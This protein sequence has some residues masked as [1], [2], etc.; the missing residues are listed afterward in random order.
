MM[1]N[2]ITYSNRLKST[3]NKK[4]YEEQEQISKK[5][6]FLQYIFELIE[7]VDVEYLDLCTSNP[8][9]NLA[10][11]DGIYI[12]QDNH[13]INTYIVDYNEDEIGEV[14]SLNTYEQMLEMLSSAI[15]SAI[16]GTYKNY[17]IN[18]EIYEFCHR[19]KS[20]IDEYDIVMNIITNKVVP[21][22]LNSEDIIINFKIVKTFIVDYEKIYDLDQSKTNGYVL[23]TKDVFG[24][25][26]PAIEVVST[27]EFDV[28]LTYVNGLHLARLY[29]K[30]GPKLLEY[31]VRSYLK[32]TSKVNRGIIETAEYYP[33]DFIAYNNGLATIATNSHIKVE[34]QG[35]VKIVEL[36]NWQ[37]VNGGQTTASLAECLSN[38]RIDLRKVT[39][40][41]KI[42]VI[43]DPKR[44]L[45][46][47]NNISL[48]S[49]TQTAIKRSDPPSNK[50]IYKQIEELSMIT[51]AKQNYE[52]FY[53][54]FE[55][56]NGQYN[57]MLKRS[58]GHDGVINNYP[59]EYKFNKIELAKAINC[60]EQVPHIVNQGQEK[61]FEYFN[62]MTDL[63]DVEINSDYF[64]K[65]YALVLLY[66]KIESMIKEKKWEYKS[67]ISSYSLSLLSLLSHR[68]I[69]LIEIWNSMEIP[70]VLVK[71]LDNIMLKVKNKLTSTPKGI[72]DVRMWAR[73][74]E[75]WYE[76]QRISTVE[77][78]PIISQE[79]RFF[80]ESDSLS[81][82]EN[83]ENIKN[84]DIW[85]RL[86]LWNANVR[87]LSP[88]Q[89]DKITSIKRCLEYKQ[90]IT[91]KLEEEC[92]SI[93]LQAVTK[94]FTY[95]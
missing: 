85:Q 18:S 59:I 34:K 42:T 73:K 35:F 23:N 16:D 21:K 55:R 64:K 61:N 43:K 33:N 39:V 54:Y 19:I 14:D 5:L 91:L 83:R 92:Q 1:N 20:K 6:I 36:N 44:S 24:I 63:I 30:E 90:S 12:E 41:V 57:T 31:N 58:R 62:K 38:E 26:L 46:L 79:T 78:I 2:M 86:L 29:Q 71:L 7:E 87:F 22:N 40:P 82:I 89:K 49:N 74:K 94:G 69:N 93:F 27:S 15:R 13:I 56:T 67:N 76:V 50:K 95:K 66:R 72:S 10:R 4:Y 45:E 17:G 77:T 47:I 80:K 48:Y 88:N 32:K 52:Q 81:F 65:A 75:C 9:N 84:I 8:A 70:S 68:R 60:W 11:I 3:I 37:I 53:C 28:Y 25:N 51:P